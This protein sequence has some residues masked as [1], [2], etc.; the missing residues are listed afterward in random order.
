MQTWMRKAGHWCWEWRWVLVMNLYLLSPVLNYE[1]RI[2]K[3]GPDKT[4]L[5]TLGASILW[6]LVAQLIGRRIWIAH[7]I[8]FPLY[9]VVGVDLYVISQYETRLTSSMLLTIFEN[10][11]DTREYLESHYKAVFGA[12]VLFLGGYGFCL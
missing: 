2:G 8:M 3:G 4:I 10:L 12:V 1:F 11:E 7:A 5:F 6:L 9:F